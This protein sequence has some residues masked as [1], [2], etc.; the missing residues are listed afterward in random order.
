MLV[1]RHVTVHHST[2]TYGG[3]VL[4]LYVVFLLYVS[5]KVL[6]AILKTVPDALNAV[7]PE[8]VL[9][10]VLPG[11]ATLGDRLVGGIDQ[12]CLDSGR[13]KLYSQK[14]TAFGNCLFCVTHNS[15]SFYCIFVTLY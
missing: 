6:V 12:H 5:T 11:M 3:K 10:L 14:R 9:Q 15:F 1:K 8:T 13:A 2:D 4:N 7:C